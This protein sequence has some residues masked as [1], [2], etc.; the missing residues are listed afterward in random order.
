MLLLILFFAAAFGLLS[1]LEASHPRQSYP[2]VKR[3]RAKGVLAFAAYLVIG[4]AAPFIW[5]GFLAEHRLFDARGWPLP[6]QIG[7]GFFIAELFGYA[8]HRMMHQ[9]P[10]LW[11][12]FHQMHHS[13]ER[14]DLSGAFWFS[15][16]DT[17][18]FAFMGSLA[19]IGVMGVSAVAGLAINIA[20]MLLTMWQH[21]NVK[22]PRWLGYFIVR[23]ESH[24]K[25]HERGRHRLNYCDLPLIDMI[26]G[27]FNNPNDIVR[28]AGFYDGAS[29][30]VGDM[31]LGRDVA[32]PARPAT[33]ALAPAE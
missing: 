14:V 20:I 4:G 19:L 3:W 6:V 18:G 8:W 22:T 24:S 7:A 29:Q 11:R 26:F 16:L 15:P 33:C 25:H 28:Q 32:G 21:L 1:F 9:T 31:L 13:A 17:I 23:P 30:R 10:F 12:W 5:D 27:T 2:P